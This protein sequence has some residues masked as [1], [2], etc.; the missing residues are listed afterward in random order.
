[1][2]EPQTSGSAMQKNRS[3]TEKGTF[4]VDAERRLESTPIPFINNIII[5][6]YL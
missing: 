4:W 5:K 1:M 6:K 2:H 3:S